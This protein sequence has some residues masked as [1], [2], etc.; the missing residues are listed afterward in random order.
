MKLVYIGAGHDQAVLEM[1]FDQLICID[2]MPMSQ[3]GTCIDPNPRIDAEPIYGIKMAPCAYPRFLN[4]LIGIYEKNGFNLV[5]LSQN[6]LHFKKNQQSI[7]YFYSTPFNTDEYSAT[8]S[9]H[10]KKSI[11]DFD[12]IYISGFMP[13]KEI[14]NYAKEKIAV[15]GSSSCC[16]LVDQAELENPVD[17]YVDY[18]LRDN[19]QRVTK[20]NL[21][22]VE[23]NDDIFSF[24]Y[25]NIIECNSIHELCEK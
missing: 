9:E 20:W 17:S 19:P 15:Y 10:V 14:M 23:W 16:Y 8:L 1:P 4:R 13:H 25:K 6:V 24:K 21:V 3:Y 12:A 11:R 18:Y 5:G 22:N 7:Q 2:S